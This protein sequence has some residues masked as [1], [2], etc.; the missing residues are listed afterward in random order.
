MEI[1]IRVLDNYLPDK[2]QKRVFIQSTGQAGAKQ[3]GM[4]Y[5]NG[6]NKN[7]KEEEIED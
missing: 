6:K 7:E 4:R 2:S 3:E 1:E 5:G